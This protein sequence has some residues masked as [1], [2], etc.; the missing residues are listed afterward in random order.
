MRVPYEGGEEKEDE[1]K[2]KGEYRK[3]TEEE[4][5]GTDNAYVK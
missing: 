3:D 5:N 4:E 2:R 1:G